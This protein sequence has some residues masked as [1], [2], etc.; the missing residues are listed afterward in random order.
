MGNKKETKQRYIYAENRAWHGTRIVALT[1]ITGKFIDARFEETDKIEKFKGKRKER[2]RL[3]FEITKAYNGEYL[4]DIYYYLVDRKEL[5][6]DG[7]NLLRRP[8]C[9]GGIAASFST[10]EMAIKFIEDRSGRKM[11]LSN[12]ADIKAY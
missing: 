4:L 6:A 10:V 5:S 1:K 11:I 9:F 8:P 3:L 2:A 12:E 7:K